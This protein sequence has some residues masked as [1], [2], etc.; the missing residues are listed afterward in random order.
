MPPMSDGGMPTAAAVEIYETSLTGGQGGAAEHLADKGSISVAMGAPPSGKTTVTVDLSMMRQTVV[1]FGAALTEASASVVQGL[2]SSKQQE[3]FNA[4][5]TDGGSGYTLARTH[6]GSCDFALTQYSYDDNGPD[7]TLANFSIDHDMNLLIPFIKAAMQ[8]SGGKLRLL[9]SPWSAPGWMKDNGVLQGNGSDGSLLPQYYGAYALYFSKYLQAYKAAGVPVWAVTT[10][11]EATGVGGS[12]EGT[13]YTA[14]QMNTFIRDNL[15]PQLQKDGL[16]DTLVLFYDHNKGPVTG[17]AVKWA[18]TIMGDTKTNPFVAGEAVHW[19]A[20]TVATYDDSMDAIHT[21]DPS[22]MILYTEGTADALGDVGYGKYSSGFQ[23]SWM[24]DQYYWQKSEGD[25]GYW[26]LKPPDQND[27]PKYEPIYRYIRDIIHGLNHWYAGFIDWNAILDKDG[28]PGHIVNPIPAAI[29][30][31][32]AAGTLYYTPIYYMMQQ[33]SKF[34]RP[35]AQVAATTVQL[36]SGVQN[37]DYDGTPTQDGDALMATAAKNADNSVSIVLFNE[38]NAPI[39]YAVV[40]GG[41]N[42]TST[43]PAQALQTL[44]WK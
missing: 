43:I 30:V 20:A 22:K 5:F 6:M 42:V 37:T 11:N 10:Q 3:F 27:H 19:Y 38:T 34:I 40:I 9:S 4:Y 12:R 21:V 29:M 16:S 32:T 36:A 13:A 31:D 8:T 7:P 24:S 14:D 18:N 17:D 33:F 41:N 23:Y 35:Q 15:G 44:V 28:G 2:D 25:W 26:F 1:G 39:D